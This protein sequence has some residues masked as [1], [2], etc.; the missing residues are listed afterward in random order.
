MKRAS[1]KPSQAGCESCREKKT[2][3]KTLFSNEDEHDYVK[4]CKDSIEKKISANIS[5]QK[6]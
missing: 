1:E 3:C 5:D 6:C 4:A 2:N